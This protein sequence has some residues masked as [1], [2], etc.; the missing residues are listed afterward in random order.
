MNDRYGRIGYWTS[1]RRRAAIVVGGL[2][3]V[4][5]GATAMHVAAATTTPAIWVEL[6]EMRP[7]CKEVCTRE[8]RAPGVVIVGTGF[9]AD[10]PAQVRFVS[11]DATRPSMTF[12]TESSS[13]TG[14][15]TLLTGE[16]VCNHWLGDP[17]EPS[18]LPDE[19]AWEVRAAPDTGK[20]GVAAISSNIVSLYTCGDGGKG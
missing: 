15:I 1:L 7:P 13:A 20:A 17:L 12:K 14:D 8:L 19:H 5:A 3:V 9:A 16:R 11:L 10:L 2:L 6:E 18:G 4:L